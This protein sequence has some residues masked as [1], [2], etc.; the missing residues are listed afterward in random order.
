MTTPAYA[1]EHLP[2]LVEKDR[3]PQIALE[4]AHPEVLF[5]V[6]NLGIG[7]SE[8]KTVCLFDGCRPLGLKQTRK[9]SSLLETID[10]M[11]QHKQNLGLTLLAEE[12]QRQGPAT[13]KLNSRESKTT[14][15]PRD[16]SSVVAGFLLLAT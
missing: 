13:R 14:C 2:S 10:Y 5:V 12:M 8:R 6:N 11:S 3:T 15:Q 4:G 9:L 7:G 1:A 16:R